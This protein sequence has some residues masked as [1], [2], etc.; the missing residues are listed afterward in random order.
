MRAARETIK[1]SEETTEEEE[2]E[3]TKDINLIQIHYISLH[4]LTKLTSEQ[5]LLL[6]LLLL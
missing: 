2:E 4:I 6:L 1:S 3:R 5:C